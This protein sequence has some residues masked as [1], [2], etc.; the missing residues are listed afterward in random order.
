MCEK[1]VKNGDDN[2]YAWFWFLPNESGWYSGR[3]ESMNVLFDEFRQPILE[4]LSSHFFGFVF[5]RPIFR[6]IAQHKIK[7]L[8]VCTFSAP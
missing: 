8:S 4:L 6:A 5:A 2:L 3:T 7:C 1:S